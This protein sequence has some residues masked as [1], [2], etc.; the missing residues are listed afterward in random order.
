MASSFLGIEIISSVSS[1]IGVILAVPLTTLTC[2]LIYGSKS[3]KAPGA[4]S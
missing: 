4:A 1:G 2:A 3:E